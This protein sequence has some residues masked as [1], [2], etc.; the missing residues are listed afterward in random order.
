MRT[1][2]KLG[3]EMFS[4][5]GPKRFMDSLKQSMSM[6]DNLDK[7]RLGDFKV[8]KSRMDV[9][10]NQSDIIEGG[11]HFYSKFDFCSDVAR[12]N[13]LACRA[14]AGFPY[15]EDEDLGT[16]QFLFKWRVKPELIKMGFFDLAC[17]KE[18]N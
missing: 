14:Q 6:F 1:Q 4:A 5:E 11:F 9:N 18:E 8:K 2:T 15:I 16:D 3:N 7:G 10:F 12:D 17:F 13:A